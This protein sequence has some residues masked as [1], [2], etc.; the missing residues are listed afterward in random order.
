MILPLH[1]TNPNAAEEVS[2]EP[3]SVPANEHKEN[4]EDRNNYK[5]WDKDKRCFLIVE[6]NINMGK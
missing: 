1:R 5:E 4:I 2:T 6:D 3:V